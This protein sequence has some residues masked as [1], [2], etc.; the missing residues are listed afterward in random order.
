MCE[1]G[2]NYWLIER[3]DENERDGGRQLKSKEHNGSGRNC[4]IQRVTRGETA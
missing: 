3:M 2:E 1:S 4:V